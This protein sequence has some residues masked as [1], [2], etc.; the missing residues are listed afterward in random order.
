MVRPKSLLTLLLLPILGSCSYGYEL[1][2]VWID[3]RIAFIIDPA[4]RYQPD[5]LSSIDVSA[6]DG[7]PKANA[8]PG[9]DERLVENGSVYWWNF[10][11]VRSCENEFPI[12]YGARLNGRPAE[13]MG[14]VAAKPLWRGVV[15]SV[16]TEGDGA[17]GSGWFKI[18]PN[19]KIENY[20][21]DPTPPVIDKDGYVVREADDEAT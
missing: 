19:G 13:S 6:D 21:S 1:L 14:Y 16:G 15:Y 11:D 9:D 2:A 3:G 8:E 7:E 12:A 17:Y 20:P 10:R 4:S 18:L 5:C